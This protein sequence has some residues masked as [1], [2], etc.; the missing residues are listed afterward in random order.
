[1]QHP[2]VH[3]CPICGNGVAHLETHH[4]IPREYGG[5]NLE[6]IDICSV[7]HRGLHNQAEALYAAA[8]SR[9]KGKPIA[10]RMYFNMHAWENAS[11]YVAVILEAR[12][13][14]ESV[15]SPDVRNRRL[16]VHVSDELLGK[17]HRLK[18]YH[19]YTSLNRFVQ[20]HLA[21]FVDAEL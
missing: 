2:E 14:F 3:H 9:D 16:I 15:G 10:T 21:A 19:G 20:D 8:K 7:C 1:M 17:L 4:I 11:R 13:N 6:T 5:Q 12:Y 18:K